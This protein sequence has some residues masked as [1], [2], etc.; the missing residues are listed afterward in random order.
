MRPSTSFADGVLG[1]DA[2]P[3]MTGTPVTPTT[4]SPALSGDVLRAYE[5]YNREIMEAGTGSSLRKQK[6]SQPAQVYAVYVVYLST[7]LAPASILEYSSSP[8]GGIGTP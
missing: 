7:T 1:M 6:Q 8:S 3:T 2:N 4:R 5:N